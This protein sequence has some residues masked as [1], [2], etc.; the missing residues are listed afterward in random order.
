M[1]Q[2]EYDVW[3]PISSTR[4]NSIRTGL[5]ATASHGLEPEPSVPPYDDGVKAADRVWNRAAEAWNPETWQGLR[6]GDRALAALLVVDG[7]VQNGG[8]AHAVEVLEP[9]ATRLG[10]EGYRYFG[11]DTVADLIDM[12][13]AQKSRLE[14]APLKAQEEVELLWDRAY[15]ELLPTDQA[16]VEAFG[17]VY[18]NSPL[19][20]APP[21]HSLHV[22][23]AP[24]PRGIPH[25]TFD[26]DPPEWVVELIPTNGGVSIRVH[27]GEAIEPELGVYR[28]RV[29]GRA[30]PGI[31]F[32]RGMRGR[33]VV[34]PGPGRVPRVTFAADAR[35]DA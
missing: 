4:L 8:V 2:R 28:V 20:F 18:A 1:V 33:L 26:V 29:D 31:G 22:P 10:V 5:I 13:S 24:R 17:V 3:R 25:V 35:R 21:D 32:E 15:R 16:L 14:V 34:R 6:A 12:A 19:D 23:L 30:V 9:D 27:H 7:L 11:L